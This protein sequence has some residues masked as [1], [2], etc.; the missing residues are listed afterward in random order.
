MPLDQRTGRY[1]TGSPL[2]AGALAGGVEIC[3]TYPM[4][5]VKV[6]FQLLSPN[7]RSAAGA[8]SFTSKV[9]FVSIITET[10]RRSGPLGLYEG[11]TP[12]LVFTLP[13]CAL[14]FATYEWLTEKANL[15]Q[16]S[17]STQGLGA[18][19][20]GAG[21]GG[22]EWAVAGTPMQNVSIKMLHDSNDG[23][24]RK[25]RSMIHAVAS[26]WREEGFIRGFYSGILPTVAKAS[27]NNGIRFAAYGEICKI[28]S[29]TNGL[30]GSKGL[31][32]V[33]SMVAGFLTGLIS[34]VVTQPIDTVKTNMQSLSADRYDRSILG[35]CREIVRQSGLV[36][37]Y[38]G[39]GPRL[40]RVPLEQA[41]LFTLYDRFGRILDRA[42]VVR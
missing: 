5:F 34:A 39:L 4:E 1:I 41:L 37:F 20:C 31:S 40:C 14:K 21:A 19:L 26:I 30:S 3:V 23:N 35:C 27:V 13:R 17:H 28:F 22:V 6:Q 9:G 29:S 18:M 12:W 16:H 24:S 38:R 32:T 10:M 15:R 11:L 8:K 25:Y 42:R 7:R 36:G 33:E 2:L